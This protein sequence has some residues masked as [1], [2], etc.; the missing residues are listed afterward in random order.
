MIKSKKELNFYIKADYMINRGYF[1][2]TF[3]QRIKNCIFPDHIMQYLVAMRKVAYYQQNGGGILSVIN[4][5]RYRKLGVKLGFSIGPN[6]FDY[7]LVIPHYGTIVVGPSNRIGKYAVLH[8][9]VCITN[10]IKEIGDSLYCSS[11]CKLIFEGKLGNGVTIGANCVVAK[12]IMKDNILLT[13]VPAVIKSE[14]PVWY[15][16]DNKYAERIALIEQL[17]RRMNI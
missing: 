3:K 6:V 15:G 14:R 2:P 11:G 5:I 13:S 4:K 10:A 1:K 7:G 16:T 12:E 8:T 17:R 9:S